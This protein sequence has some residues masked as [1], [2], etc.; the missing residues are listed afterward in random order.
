M[1]ILNEPWLHPTVKAVYFRAI[2]QDTL[3]FTETEVA[4][5]EAYIKKKL[6]RFKPQP[7][8]IYQAALAGGQGKL[9]G[10][11]LADYGFKKACESKNPNTKRQIEIWVLDPKDYVE[12][13]A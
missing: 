2:A 3:G 4:A 12:P 11:L 9:I 13:E 10:P 1:D 7:G 5:T 6:L 8:I